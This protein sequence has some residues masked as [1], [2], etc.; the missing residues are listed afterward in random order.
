M[1]SVMNEDGSYTEEF[2]NTVY[3][4]GNVE[5]EEASFLYNKD[6]FIIKGVTLTPDRT[7]CYLTIYLNG[8][9]IDGYLNTEPIICRV[10]LLEPRYIENPVQPGVRLNKE[11]RS[12]LTNFAC[13]ELGN[14]ILSLY[15]TYDALDIPIDM[16]KWIKLII[17]G[18]RQYSLLETVD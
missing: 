15:Y 2:I 10:S 7:D 17:E 11:Q 16:N 6:N 3:L 4:Y 12:I 5:E 9:M 14:I 8:F 13:Y 1:K 18:K